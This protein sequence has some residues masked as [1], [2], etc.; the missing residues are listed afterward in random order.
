MRSTFLLQ[1][2]FDL[3]CREDKRRALRVSK[4]VGVQRSSYT[5]SILLRYGVTIHFVSGLMHWLVSQS[6]LL[7]LQDQYGAVDVRHSFSTCGFSA[8]A[9]FVTLPAGLAQ[10]LV[11]V[12][13]GFRKCDGVMRMVSTNS[14][15]ISAAWHVLEEDRAE[16][17]LVLVIRGVVEMREDGIGHCSFTTAPQE[18]PE[19]NGQG[20][21]EVSMPKALLVSTNK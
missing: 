15:A 20:V 16:A 17:H 2:E 14:R 3:M 7:T 18:G 4:P 5:I 19:V 13:L 6:L 10:I 12:L 8:L 9:V 11:M 21:R 1:R